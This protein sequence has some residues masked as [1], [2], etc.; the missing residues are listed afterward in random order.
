MVCKRFQDS[1]LGMVMVFFARVMM[2]EQA[3]VG[4]MKT[5]RFAKSPYL[6][7]VGLVVLLL[8][9][10]ACGASPAD[11]RGETGVQPTAVPTTA[12]AQRPTYTVERGDVSYQVSFPARISPVIEEPL[13]FA[14]SGQVTA[15]YAGRNDNVRAGDVL[16]ELD[17]AGLEEALFEAQAVYEIAAA[18]L[19]GVQNELD[20]QRRR[21]EIAV[22]MAQLD[23]EFAQ[24]Q[25][26][27]APTP[28]QLYQ[29]GR[30]EL[31]LELAELD[32]SELAATADPALQADVDAAQLRISELETQLAQT[33][34]V[35]PFDGQILSLNLAEGEQ[36][37]ADDIVGLIADPNQLEVSATL[38]SA[39]F[40]E[41]VEGMAASIV[42]P[43]PPEG[44]FAATVRQLPFTGTGSNPAEGDVR[45]SFD[46]VEDAAGFELGDRVTVRI[47]VDSH[48]NVL[49]LPPAAV[50][51]FNGRKFVVVQD[52]DFQRRV[53]VALGLVG[54]ERVE[55]TAGLSEGEVVVGQ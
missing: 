27:E 42:F 38:T 39:R 4:W 46:N 24:T 22:A 35:A 30:L 20:S 17:T 15:V 33:E 54:A 36:V 5:G 52:G 47:V 34:L 45:V 16:A 1:F 37:T 9:T 49:W 3:V 48:S 12:A 2:G 32:L 31:Q 53:D 19:A 28:E 7:M 10:A 6:Q 44:L 26:G 8:V 11:R 13:A 50:R 21:A 41:L 51:D 29:I 25:A 40:Q 23:L 18:R 14:I 55:I 43:G